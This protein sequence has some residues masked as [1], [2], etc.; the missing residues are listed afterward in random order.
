MTD[1]KDDNNG[2]IT[3]SR[4]EQYY[5]TLI[6]PYYTYLYVNNMVNVTISV[7]DE[8][9][10]LLDKHQEMNWS[11][12]ARQAWWQKVRELE[13]LNSITKGSKAT[14]KGVMELAKLIK[15]GI[16]DWHNQK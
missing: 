13:L 8:L 1:R 9:K 3:C 14:D 7:P 2:R 4:N 11:E 15:K 12:V 5:I 6:K 10:S 16:A